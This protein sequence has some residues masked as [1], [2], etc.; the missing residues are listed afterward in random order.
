MHY[1]T[2]FLLMSANT[3]LNATYI[4]HHT[5]NHSIEIATDRNKNSDFNIY[6]FAGGDVNERVGD[7]KEVLFTQRVDEDRYTTGVYPNGES[8]PS[9]TSCDSTKRTDVLEVQ[10]T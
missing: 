7:Q 8:C 6:D 10:G 4:H 9:D 2:S 5:L 3:H 1:M